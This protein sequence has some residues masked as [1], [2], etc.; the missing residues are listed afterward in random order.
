[1]K[2]IKKIKEKGIG[3]TLRRIDSKYGIGRLERAIASNW[4]NPFATLWLNFRS[5]PFKQAIK[6]PIFVYGRPRFYCTS[7]K[8]KFVCKPKMGMVTFN[9]T[10]PG[11]P[12]MG[13]VQ[14]EFSNAGV[15]HFHGIGQIDTGTR[16]FVSNN[17][18]L[19]IGDHF[20]ISDMINFCCTHKITIGNYVRIAHRS[21]VFDNNYHSVANLKR[22]TIPPRSKEINIGNNVWICNSTTINGG[23][24]IPDFV[25]V[26]SN[27]HIS[28]DFSTCEPGT[29]IGGIPA[30]VIGE[31]SFRLENDKLEDQLL[32]YYQ[33]TNEPFSIAEKSLTLEE[34]VPGLSVFSNDTH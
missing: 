34:I 15:I 20:K 28:K 11:S 16:F 33:N 25:I 27:S 19:E 12:C 13:S 9:R 18:T 2:L 10:H 26:S 4:L 31:K 32:E 22:G 23:T 30:K 17:G 29:V 5:L 24:K 21:Q 8:I 3:Y 6:L 14:S 1:M 7:G